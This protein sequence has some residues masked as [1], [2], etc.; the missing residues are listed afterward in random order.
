MLNFQPVAMPQ[1]YVICSHPE[2]LMGY[3][4]L[5]KQMKTPSVKSITKT[6]NICIFFPYQSTNLLLVCHF[7]R[8]PSTISQAYNNLFKTVIEEFLYV[9][10]EIFSRC[11]QKLK[12]PHRTFLLDVS[13]FH[14]P[15]TYILKCRM[16]S[17]E[18]YKLQTFSVKKKFQ[19]LLSIHPENYNWISNLIRF[20]YKHL[21]NCE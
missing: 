13:G 21:M 6:E 7:D 14:T 18:C 16:W 12:Q 20:L 5:I 8:W 19:P 3:E 2:M 1:F 17:A 15:S 9:R 10:Y 11:R 4:F